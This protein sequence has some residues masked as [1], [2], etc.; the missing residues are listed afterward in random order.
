METKPN[1]DDWTN[2]DLS[3]PEEPVAERKCIGCGAPVND[4]EVPPCGH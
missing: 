2:P 4:G 3:L 1:L